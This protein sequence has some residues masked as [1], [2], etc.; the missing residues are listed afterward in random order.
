MLLEKFVLC[1]P[2]PLTFD[3][4]S[5]KL[6][7]Y[8]ASHNQPLRQMSV[9]R[10]FFIELWQFISDQLCRVHRIRDLWQDWMGSETT[11]YL[12]SS[13][14]EFPE[15]P[16]YCT[17]FMRLLWRFKPFIFVRFHCWE[18]SLQ[19]AEI[20]SSEIFSPAGLSVRG[21]STHVEAHMLT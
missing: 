16:T 2:W 4:A 7:S 11:V 9:P 8:K 19:Y 15:M 3:I 10:P 20:L 14:R 1:W 12:E 13:R 17:T 6:N 18:R 5:W 21:K